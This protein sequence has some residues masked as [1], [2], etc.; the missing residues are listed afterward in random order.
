MSAASSARRP[1]DSEIQWQVSAKY[2]AKFAFDQTSA[3][4]LIRPEERY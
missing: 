1:F 4:R 3:V 2:A